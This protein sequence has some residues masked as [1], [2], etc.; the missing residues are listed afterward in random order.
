MGPLRAERAP[1]PVATGFEGTT[2]GSVVARE[3]VGG[4]HGGSAAG[5]R[6]VRTR[7][8]YSAQ[9]RTNSLYFYGR[10]EA[11][12]VASR[13]AMGLPVTGERIGALLARRAGAPLGLYR[14]V[15]SQGEGVEWC[16]ADHA[17]VAFVVRIQRMVE[18]QGEAMTMTGRA[19]RV[20]PKA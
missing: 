6:A 7:T 11:E 16:P 15:R 14:F 4:G 17:C 9:R 13:L 10:T 18:V 12:E 8:T 3:V 2:M 19:F 5:E 20:T 1:R